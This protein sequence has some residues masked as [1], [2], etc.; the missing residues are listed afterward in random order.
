M[1][2]ISPKV[3]YRVISPFRWSLVFGFLSIRAFINS[4]SSIDG[5]KVKNYPAV[6]A[7]TCICLRLYS[8]I[9]PC[10]GHGVFSLVIGAQ[11]L[12]KFGCPSCHHHWFF[13]DSNP[14]LPS[15][16][17][18]IITS[19]LHVYWWLFWPCISTSFDKILWLFQHFIKILIVTVKRARNDPQPV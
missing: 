7:Y 5:Q 3:Q 16:K 12:I 11:E 8:H 1:Y 2:F 10:G 19:A 17:L 18:C 6:I 9:K 14:Q 15:H 4:F 13:W